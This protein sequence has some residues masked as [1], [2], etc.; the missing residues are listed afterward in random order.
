MIVGVCAVA[1]DLMV[2][3]SLL[4]LLSLSVSKLF[5]F[6]SG[7]CVSF[8]F[9]K[10]WTFKVVRRSQ[11]ELGRFAV[12]YCVSMS[13]NVGLNQL[14]FTFSGGSIFG[15][16]LAATA[17]STIINFVGQRYWVFSTNHSRS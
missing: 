1:V 12:L 15:A 13:I 10:Y 2:Y 16:F 6:L 17:V 8:I 4:T 3:Q 14:M 9:N 7:T 5:G 11:K